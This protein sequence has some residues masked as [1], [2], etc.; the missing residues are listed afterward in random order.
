MAKKIKFKNPIPGGSEYLFAETIEKTAEGSDFNYIGRN[1][2]NEIVFKILGSNL[3]IT[4][5]EA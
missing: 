3:D 2:D 5:E 4:V 1:K